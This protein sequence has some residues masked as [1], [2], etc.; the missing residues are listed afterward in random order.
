[1]DR[2]AC[3]ITVT[4]ATAVFGDAVLIMRPASQPGECA[5]LEP[6]S[7]QTLELRSS[8]L[9]L[10]AEESVPVTV[11]AD[12][13]FEVR[14][15]IP[16]GIRLGDA[17]VTAIP[18][19]D[20]DCAAV[21][22]V[23]AEECILP[24]TYF[25][26]GFD[27]ADLEPLRI[28]SVDVETPALPPDDALLTSYVRVGPGTDELTVVIWGS[29][30]AAR[31]VAFVRTAPSDRLEIVSDMPVPEGQACAALAKPWT[32]VIHLPAGATGYRTVSV[33]NVEA[34]LLAG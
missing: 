7:T 9:G 16:P 12:G 3:G 26:V 11:G 4:P 34:V 25:T 21:P 6:G 30:C 32:T 18:P 2:L 22:A 5:T 29:S 17:V 23:P 10:T 31:P 14:M 1:M 8:I 27:P 19:A 13:G 24:R 33:D 15:R 28:T 20:L